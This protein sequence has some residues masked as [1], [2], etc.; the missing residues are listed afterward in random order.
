MIDFTISTDIARAP[1]EVFAYVTDPSKL[2]TWQTNTLSAVQ[3]TEGPMG[4]GTRIREVHRAAGRRFE[5]LVEVVAYEPARRFELHVV[6]G[7]PIDA[8]ITF[9][10]SD[11]GGTRMQFRVFGQ[12][13]GVMRL[14]QP[15]LK[16]GMRRNFTQYCQA[17]KRVLEQDQPS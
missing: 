10:P 1:D 5:E 6:E 8:Q 2:A 12:P 4:L 9:A 16:P 13:T 17:L 15:V 3:E 7:P 14:L 11:V